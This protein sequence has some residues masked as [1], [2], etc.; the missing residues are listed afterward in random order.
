MDRWIFHFGISCKV[1]TFAE[2]PFFK[3]YLCQEFPSEADKISESIK[4]NPCSVPVWLPVIIKSVMWQIWL[5]WSSVAF[6][7][8]LRIWSFLIQIPMP[9]TCSNLFM[10]KF[11][12]AL[13]FTVFSHNP[14]LRFDANWENQEMKGKTGFPG[15]ILTCKCLLGWAVLYKTYQFCS[16]VLLWAKLWIWECGA[17]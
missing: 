16:S 2:K 15:V 17:S 9:E 6:W 7:V 11:F 3:Q 10:L 13:F 14:T 12:E 1:N 4:K 8:C 5:A